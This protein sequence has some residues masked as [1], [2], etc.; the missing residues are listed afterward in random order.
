VQAT[1]R[2]IDLLRDRHNDRFLSLGMGQLFDVIAG[3]LFTAAAAPAHASTTQLAPQMSLWCGH[4]TTLMPVLLMLG[5]NISR[6]PPYASSV[7]RTLA[8]A[9]CTS[10]TAINLYHLL[11]DLVTVPLSRVD[12]A[13]N[14]LARCSSVGWHLLRD[15][16]SAL[17][18]DPQPVTQLAH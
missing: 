18:A 2:L 12:A 10:A 1:E 5:Q 15:C 16:I 14:E 17:L 9:A 7:V 4:D 11:L 3:R 8:A 6:W 13:S